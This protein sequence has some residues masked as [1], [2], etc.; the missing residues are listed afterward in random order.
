MKVVTDEGEE[1]F[2]SR[3]RRTNVGRQ[4]SGDWAT[5]PMHECWKAEMSNFMFCSHV[6]FQQFKSAPFTLQMR[7]LKA[8]SCA[9]MP[10]G[11]DKSGSKVVTIREP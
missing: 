10:A 1:T 3:D 9:L 6:L 8:C 4:T 2:P 7:N 11:F 5:Q